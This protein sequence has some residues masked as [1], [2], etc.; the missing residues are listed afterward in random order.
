MEAY[1]QEAGRAGPGPAGTTL[2]ENVFSYLSPQDIILQK[3]LIEQTVAQGVGHPGVREAKLE[4][5]GPAFI[6]VIQ[7]FLG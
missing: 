6:Q 5:Y 3:Y 1:Y 2:P 7:E 4:K